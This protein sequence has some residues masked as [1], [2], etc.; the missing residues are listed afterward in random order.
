MA[1][2][3]VTACAAALSALVLCIT[4]SAS[5]FTTYLEPAGDVYDVRVTGTN[6]SFEKVNFAAP[7]QD[8]RF[9]LRADGVTPDAGWVYDYFRVQATGLSVQPKD[10]VLD[11][12]IS[13]SWMSENNADLRTAAL[14]IFDEGNMSWKRLRSVKFSE[15]AGYMH[16]RAESPSLEGFFAVTAEPVPVQI[17]FVLHC[18]GDGT[19]EPQSG[20]D[21]ESCGDCQLALTRTKCAP[22]GAYC[23]G[24]SLF[25]CS[26]DG[27]DYAIQE[28]ENGCLNGRCLE[29]PAPTGM[30]VAASPVF[31]VVVVA[32]VSVIAYMVFSLR[33]IRKK[34]SSV[35]RL[36]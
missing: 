11:F 34:I 20:E 15:D 18:D 33:N 4:V 19:C 7:G 12:R 25:T 29:Y 9:L 13:K 21:E 1:S 6:L 5:S 30:A 17:D 2:I 23:S 8:E 16:F 24:D 31:I 10:V 28:C 14:S 36:R 35:E 3:K 22:F 27:S 32:L 26:S